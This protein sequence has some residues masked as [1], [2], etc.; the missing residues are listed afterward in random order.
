MQ[1]QTAQEVL[2]R[3]KGWL[4]TNPPVPGTHMLTYS[5]IG[6][7]CDPGIPLQ[8]GSVE[9]EQRTKEIC[10]GVCFLLMIFFPLLISYF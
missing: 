4:Q 3:Q 5:P 6:S 1:P 7:D 9:V 2:Q 10:R 8:V